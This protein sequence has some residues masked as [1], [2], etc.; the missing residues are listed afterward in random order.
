MIIGIG[1]IGGYI[2]GEYDCK[3]IQ[4]V[5][6]LSIQQNAVSHINHDIPPLPE[7]MNGLRGTKL[8]NGD[9][10]ICSGRVFLLYKNGSNQ[11]KKSLTLILY[12]M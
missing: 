1:I 11:C 8:Q 3:E 7:G 12:V 10:L 4:E 2:G 5:E 9:L 6:V